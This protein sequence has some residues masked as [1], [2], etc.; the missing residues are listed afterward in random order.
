MHSLLPV[1]RS[2]E[3]SVQIQGSL[4]AFSPL[5]HPNTQ[6]FIW[7]S[8]KG[9]LS[10][11]SQLS[12]MNFFG[13]CTICLCSHEE[14]THSLNVEEN[15]ELTLHIFLFSRI[16]VLWRSLSNA[17]KWFYDIFGCYRC[18]CWECKSDNTFSFITRNRIIASS[19]P[20]L[21]IY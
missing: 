10:L 3:T 15:V 17:R 14:S 9:F 8:S 2:K 7:L 5:N 16:T 13:L 18:S 1:K 11:P 12:K 6:D 4:F 19:W 21:K 20:L